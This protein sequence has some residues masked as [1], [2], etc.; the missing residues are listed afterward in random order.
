MSVKIRG[1]TSQHYTVETGKPSRNP[2]NEL[3]IGM[4]PTNR[5]S[6]L[7]LSWVDRSNPDRRLAG[8]IPKS[9]SFFGFT[10]GI[11]DSTAQCG[12]TGFPLFQS[13][14]ANNYLV[15]NTQSVQN[16]YTETQ[17]LKLYDRE[18][19]HYLL[20]YHEFGYVC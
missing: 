7:D 4:F 18:D 15:L 19:L 16:T 3:D 17:P 20:L 2:K 1:L 8:N 9:N 12:V 10:D 6:G 5:L 13:P 11:P 14:K